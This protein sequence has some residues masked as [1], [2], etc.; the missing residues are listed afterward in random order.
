MTKQSMTR[1]ELLKAALAA[2][3]GLTA[4]AFLPEKWLKPM[5]QSGVLPVHAQTSGG[6]GRIVGRAYFGQGK[7][8]IN[9]RYIEIFH[10]D[11]KP[12]VA[13]N[14]FEGMNTQ[15]YNSQDGWYGFENLKPGTYTVLDHY[16]DDNYGSGTVKAGE[17]ITINFEETV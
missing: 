7:T 10:G 2:G 4:A 5:V 1:R 13:G 15:S 8:G 14:G 11:L 6:N 16:D 12:P 3:T 9:N 17:T